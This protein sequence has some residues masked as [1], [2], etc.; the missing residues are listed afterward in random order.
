MNNENLDKILESIDLSSQPPLEEPARQYYFLKKCR[1]FVS[2]EEKRLGRK[3][4]ACVTT[5]GCQMNARDS[6]KLSGILEQ[7]GYQLTDSEEADFDIYNTCTVRDNADQRVYGRLGH[8]NGL[9]KKNPH[10]K[11]ALCGCMMQEPGT[12][13]KIRKS[14]RFVDLIFGTHNIY[15]F[16]ELLASAWEQQG[17]IVDIWQNTDKIVEDLPVERKYSFKSGINI[18]FGCNN[19]CSYCIVPYV[20]GRERSRSP[21]DIIK[22]I[23]NLVADGVVEIMLL[24][25]NVNSFGKNL[26]EPM[27]FAGLLREVEKIDGLQRIRFMTSHPKDLSDELI[28]VMAASS[29]ICRH[30]HLPLQ[31]G[32]TRILQAMNRRYTKEQYLELVDKIR[33]AMPD[34]ALTTDIIVG[35]P[36]ETPEDVDETIDVIKKVQFDNAF[37]FIYSKRTGTPAAAMEN[38]VSE[39]VVKEGFDRVLRTVQETARERVRLLSGLTMEALVEEQNEQDSTL[40]TGRLSNNTL[41][42]FPGDASLIGRIVPV[43]LKEYKGFYFLGEMAGGE[44]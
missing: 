5:F 31:S 37:T 12:I 19:F 1:V 39:E 14:Y 17:M 23:E 18:M 24:G 43:Y 30:L 29:K 42:H 20:R 36:G 10:M 3:L 13:E 11:I 32:S 6:E 38:Q 33:T 4:T 26:E 8:L 35:F 7:A 41:V 2:E 21:K 28:E 25:Q 9:K 22:E 44:G 40:V 34:I 16:A 15:K 27:S